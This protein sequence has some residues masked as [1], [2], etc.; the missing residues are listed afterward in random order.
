VALH[1]E[2][3]SGIPLL[4]EQMKTPFENQECPK[5][6]YLILK[7]YQKARRWTTPA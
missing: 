2:E 6:F 3:C 7:G 1:R 5:L 4:D